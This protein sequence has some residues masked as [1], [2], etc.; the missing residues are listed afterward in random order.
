VARLYEENPSYRGEFERAPSRYWS[1]WR[2][3]CD[4]AD[5]IVVN[6]S[7]SYAALV[8]E[9][10]PE[11]KIRIVSLAY[12]EPEASR[13]FRRTYP[14]AFTPSRPLRVLFL[15]QI[16]LRKGV[17]PMF[18]AVRLLRGE[19][20][21]FWFVGPMQISIPPDL[22]EDRQVRWIGPVL[23]HETAQ[24]YRDADLF[25]FPTFSD[26][27]GLTQLEAQAWKLPIV[28]TK[29]CGDVVRHGSNGWLLPEITGPAI[30]ATLR[31]CLA[32]PKRLQEASDHCSPPERFGLTN[33]GQQW[34]QVFQ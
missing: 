12:E 26:G 19:P 22:R 9:G 23:H 14:V 33:V 30:A 20:I 32:Q 5:R 8:E 17:G 21:E 27:F 25:V 6:S 29:F 24:F 28:A 1:S 10:V 34:L 2:E 15:G 11:E 3:E 18:D 7:W 16:N 31:Q 4:L 13:Q